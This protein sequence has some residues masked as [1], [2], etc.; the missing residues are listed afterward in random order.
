MPLSHV[1]K[2]ILLLGTLF[3]ASTLSAEH[4]DSLGDA[5]NNWLDSLTDVQKERALYPFNEDR[6]AWHF[7]PKVREAISYSE[8]SSDQVLLANALLAQS[9]SAQGLSP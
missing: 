9:L 4:H 7:I 3:S 1:F 2:T 5:A 6:K 8:M